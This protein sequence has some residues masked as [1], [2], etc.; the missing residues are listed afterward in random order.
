MK[1]FKATKLI[2]LLS[3][4]CLCGIQASAA[5]GYIPSVGVNLPKDQSSITSASKMLDADYMYCETTTSAKYSVVYEAKGSNNGRSWYV[6][7]D[8]TYAKGKSG[9]E[10]ISKSYNYWK[11]TLTGNSIENPK[12]KCIAFGKV[13]E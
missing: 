13:S 8:A 5:G 4:L 11:I 2:G 6:A 7:K 10:D 1:K 9:N 3:I 12:K